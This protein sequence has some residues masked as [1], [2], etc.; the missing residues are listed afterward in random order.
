MS[1]LLF[2]DGSIRIGLINIQFV[3]SR[4]SV[5][6]FISAYRLSNFLEIMRVIKRIDRGKC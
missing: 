6:P 2:L 5:Y 4:R 3:V 1:L